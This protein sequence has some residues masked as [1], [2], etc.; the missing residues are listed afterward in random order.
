LTG[1]VIANSSWRGLVGNLEFTSTQPYDSNVFW[2]ATTE[3]NGKLI[4]R[5]IVPDNQFIITPL[6]DA[7]LESNSVVKQTTMPTSASEGD[8]WV[9]TLNDENYVYK[10]TD[11]Y[12][13]TADQ[14][15]LT[16][17]AEALA[18]G[19]TT[20]LVFTA[21]A[22][23]L[24]YIQVAITTTLSPAAVAT[25]G[26]GTRVDPY[27]ITFSLP[28]TDN[29]NNTII[30]LA[31]TTGIVTATGADADFGALTDLAATD[32]ENPASLYWEPR[33]IHLI[34]RAVYP[35]LVNTT[36]T[37][38]ESLSVLIR[39]GDCIPLG[40]ASKLLK[41]VRGD[42][43]LMIMVSQYE[44]EFEDIIRRVRYHRRLTGAPCDLVP[45]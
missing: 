8:Y 30:G 34:Y 18:A 29:S 21:V 6:Y 27:V 14:A 19:T 43:R 4:L 45:L 2:Q 38:D 17:G 32:L 16:I 11:N 5:D 41:M 36:D 42:Q 20:D 10:A 35:K 13:S 44:K 26:A 40:A 25:T 28:V 33:Y 9:D 23:G 12:S 37:L 1:Q 7:N 31:A 39:E 3:A 24:T 15:T 22:T